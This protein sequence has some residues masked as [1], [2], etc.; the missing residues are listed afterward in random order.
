MVL[1][2][3]QVRWIKAILANNGSSTDKE[4]IAHFVKEGGV[5]KYIAEAWV[6]KRR[7]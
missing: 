5:P 3:I 1:S 6:A 4:L 7:E 2:R